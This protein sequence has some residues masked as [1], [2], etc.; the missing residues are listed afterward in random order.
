MP[1]CRDPEVVRSLLLTDEPGAR[2]ISNL[3]TGRAGGR[4]V[5]TRVDSLSRPQAIVCRGGA[6]H[7]RQMLYMYAANTPAAARVLDE[8]P[9]RWRLEFAATSGELVPAVRQAL[10]KRGRKLNWVSP[11]YLYVLEPDRL[12][13]DRTHCVEYLR[14]VDARLIAEYWPHGRNADYIRWR[15]RTGPSCAIR[16]D[17]KLVAWAITHG[18]GAMGIL[19]VLD[20]YRGQGMARSITTA[21]AERCLQVG[22]Q[23]FLYIV[24]KNNASVNLTESMG[25]RRHSVVAWF[26]E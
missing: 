15:I 9:R 2:S 13:I 18:D 21:L 20:E 12:V 8:I 5:W 24:K 23:P 17:G 11:C 1:I 3:I 6:L 4:A 19:H 25:F 22:L 7:R 26:G 16:R 14:P 10:R